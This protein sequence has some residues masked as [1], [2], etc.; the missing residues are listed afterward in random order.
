MSDG[1]TVTVVNQTDDSIDG[2]RWAA[3]V[4]DVLV[5]EGV[6]APAETTVVFVDVAEMTSLNLEH[7]GGDGPTDVLS[8]PIDDSDGL[9]GG[10]VSDGTGVRFVGD[11]VVCAEV[12]AANAPDHAGDVD[13]E[14]ALLLVHGALHL[15]GHNHAE[16]DELELMWAAERRH[17]A[18]AW[19]PL[20]RDPWVSQ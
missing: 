3:L 17:L 6:V 8:F 20:A 7:M 2:D 12:A 11:I 19:R 9:D 13:D 15:L 14:I 18:R 5:D 1:V 4:R 16:P 10:A